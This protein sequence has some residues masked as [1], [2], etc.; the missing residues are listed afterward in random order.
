MALLLE[1]RLQFLD[2]RK[3]GAHH[4]ATAPNALEL[5]TSETSAV[6]VYDDGRIVRSMLAA[7]YALEGVP[8]AFDFPFLAGRRPPPQNE[9]RGRV[10]L[11]GHVDGCV[12]LW[13][14]TGGESKE[15]KHKVGRGEG[16]GRGLSSRHVCSFLLA[17]CLPPLPSSFPPPQQR[18]STNPISCSLLVHS[19]LPHSFADD[20]ILLLALNPPLLDGIPEDI[21][22]LC[23]C[24]CARV[25]SSPSSAPL[26]SPP[27]LHIHP[28][29]SSP[30]PLHPP[31]ILSTS[32]CPPASSCCV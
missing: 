29:S 32:S 12:Q 26:Q 5:H 25:S 4:T 18:L 9:M 7:L 21:G 19:L 28:P 24:A 30:S 10:V 14:H 22:A 15:K 23:V 8:V 27:P 6:R 16:R 17:T 13:H 1:D 20:L 31:L 3:G 11:T 2:V